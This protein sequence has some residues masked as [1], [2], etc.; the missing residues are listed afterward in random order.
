MSSPTVVIQLFKDDKELI[1]F[2]CDSLP[3]VLDELESVYIPGIAYD[4]QHENYL[5][6]LNVKFSVEEIETKITHMIEEI[7]N[8]F[9]IHLQDTKQYVGYTPKDV[10]ELDTICVE[11]YNHERSDWLMTYGKVVGELNQISD[12]ITS[13]TYEKKGKFYLYMFLD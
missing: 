1:T 6:S 13:K 11:N 9:H 2:T 8:I 4:A 7:Y 3:R 10:E 12:I 5:Y